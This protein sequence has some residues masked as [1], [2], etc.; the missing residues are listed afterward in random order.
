[1][2]RSFKYF[3]AIYGFRRVP[4]A[5]IREIWWFIRVRKASDCLGFCCWQRCARSATSGARHASRFEISGKI[6][7]AD[8]E[9][10]ASQVDGAFD[11][12]E[13]IDLLLIMTDFED[14][15]AGA[16]FDGLSMEVQARSI[17]HV[18]RYGV[19]GAPALARAMIEAFGQ[20]SGQRADLRLS[21]QTEAR[22]WVKAASD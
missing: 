6:T 5:F 9:G 16:V 17:R 10:M 15:D 7:K 4:A 12:L 21:E 3:A 22:A 8:I 18:R 2:K 19:I 1:L 20:V 11:A 14:L 13:T